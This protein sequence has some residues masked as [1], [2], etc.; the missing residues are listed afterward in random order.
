M[1]CAETVNATIAGIAAVIY[2][3]TAVFVI[4]YWKETQR[5]KDQMMEQIGVSKKQ[6]KSS[7]MPV[8]DAIIH[9]VKPK[10]E[11]A[12]SQIQFAYDLFLVNK[13]S[14]PA[15]NVSV[16]RTPS[17][18]RSQKEAVRSAPVQQIDHFHKAI[19]IIA[20]DERV[21]IHREHSD[22]YRA[23][24]LNVLFYDVLR[25]RYTSEFHGDRDELS[26]KTYDI[27]RLEDIKA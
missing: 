24:T 13:G 3:V 21:F 11:M 18:T 8:L 5:M 9:T 16:Q 17:V 15:F 20:K 7:T 4:L 2:A 6:L 12:G 25:D 14:G 26:L 27:M 1:T 22:S 19:N 23:Y 10:P